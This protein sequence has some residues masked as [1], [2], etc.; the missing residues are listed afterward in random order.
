MH[1]QLQ[2]HSEKLSAEVTST[3][4][5]NLSQSQLASDTD[6]IKS[7]KTKPVAKWITSY[8]WD[9]KT[10]HHFCACH[11][12]G[13]VVKHGL[14][15]LG[16]NARPGP[17]NK[18]VVL[19]RFPVVD[20]MPVIEEEVEDNDGGVADEILEE[21]EQPEHQPDELPEEDHHS[22]SEEASDY[23]DEY[24]DEV[25]RRLREAI[26][27]PPGRRS[28]SINTMATLHKNVS[29][30]FSSMDMSFH[31]NILFLQLSQCLTVCRRITRSASWRRVFERR[32][33]A[34]GLLVR[35]LSA[36]Y[37]IRWNADHDRQ[38]RAYEAREVSIYN[39]VI[40][41]YTCQSR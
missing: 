12:L 23:N 4:D 41:L 17:A 39:H 30:L 33:K 8:T 1:K 16:I 3:T 26:H 36:G 13:L 20:I 38:S 18:E 6:T 24:Q 28:S 15:A 2:A 37:G 35:P 9:P 32:M 11:K 14:A 40:I 25:T 21:D 7:M 10:M 27:D 22:D 34:K 5:L 19:G 31:F 29:C